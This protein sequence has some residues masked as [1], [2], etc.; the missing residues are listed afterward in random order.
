MTLDVIYSGISI[1]ILLY[2]IYQSITD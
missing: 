1:V 2:F